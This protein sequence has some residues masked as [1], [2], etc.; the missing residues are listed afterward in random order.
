MCVCACVRARVRVCACA[1][2][3]VCVCVRETVVHLQVL[4]GMI[5]EVPALQFIGQF[6]Q[7]CDICEFLTILRHCFGTL[8]ISQA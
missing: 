4:S 1:R 3:R 5:C 7:I 8:V 2:V 6:M